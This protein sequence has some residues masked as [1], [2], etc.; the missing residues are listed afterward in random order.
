MHCF[1]VGD[2]E[3]LFQHFS[4]LYSH[5][6][7]YML[8]LKLVFVH[9][10]FFVLSSVG[11]WVEIILRLFD[12]LNCLWY[13]ST[14][15]HDMRLIHTD[16][17]PENILFVSPNYIKVPDYKVYCSPGDCRIVFIL[18]KSMLNF[19]Y[20]GLL[21]FMFLWFS[22]FIIFF[23]EEVQ[24]DFSIC[25]LRHGQPEMVDLYVKGCPSQVL[26]RSLTLVA[27]H[28]SSKIITILSLQDIIVHLKLF[29]VWYIFFCIKLLWL[30]YLY[31]LCRI[32]NVTK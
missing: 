27:Q 6:N 7:L 10:F 29:W 23:L 13:F 12:T 18:L 30:L 20:T 15:L 8:F 1:L 14:V 25:R 11:L 22:I 16:L 32:Y 2:I 26:L 19:S 28:M 21:L 24:W 17:K 31:G 4:S 3:I 9:N 5:D